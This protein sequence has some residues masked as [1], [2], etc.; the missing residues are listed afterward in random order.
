M[1]ER[2]EGNPPKLAPP[3]GWVGHVGNAKS[4]TEKSSAAIFTLQTHNNNS[5]FAAMSLKKPELVSR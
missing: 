5:D 2:R 3:V 4:V 1:D